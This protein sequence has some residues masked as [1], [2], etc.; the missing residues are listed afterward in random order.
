LLLLIKE[1]ATDTEEFCEGVRRVL[2]MQLR[3]CVSHSK[4]RD[5][6]LTDSE[7]PLLLIA[8]LTYYFVSLP[9]Q[10][11]LVRNKAKSSID[12]SQES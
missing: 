9:D 8:K 5:F 1:D 2:L 4:I 3:H 11:P 12:G 10:L 6:V 7:I